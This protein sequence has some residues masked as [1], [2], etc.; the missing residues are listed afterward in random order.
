MTMTSDD[1][2]ERK[3]RWVE[4]L[5]VAGGMPRTHRIEDDAMYRR[6]IVAE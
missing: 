5:E 4:F 3:R 2:F 1:Y 6:N